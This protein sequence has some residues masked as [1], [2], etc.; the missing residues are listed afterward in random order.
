MKIAVLAYGSR[1]DVQPP[2]ALAHH[3]IAR[4]HEVTLGVPRD[5]FGEGLD[6][7]VRASIDAAIKFYE[8]KGCK[9]VDIKLPHADLGL[10][11][12]YII[13]TAEASSNLER[14][15]GIRYGLSVPADVIKEVYTKT[16]AAGFGPEVRRRILIGTFVLRFR[17]DP[18][19]GR[20]PG[21][22]IES[23]ST[24]IRPIAEFNQDYLHFH[25]APQEVQRYFDQLER[26]SAT[27]AGEG[28]LG[29]RG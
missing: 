15:D 19:A 26:P 21:R 22:V 17:D 27:A 25:G 28:E 3:L 4:G 2:L 9:I 5:F 10:P 12:Y 11:V 20:K 23:T 8:G 14:Y 18:T 16:R 1:G 24:R 29:A 13:A 7:E 6:P